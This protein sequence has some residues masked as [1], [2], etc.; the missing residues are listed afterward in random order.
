MVGNN[1][2]N[3]AC[4]IGVEVTRGINAGLYKDTGELVV[5]L[6]TEDYRPAEEL[7][8]CERILSTIIEILNCCRVHKNRIRGIGI[9]GD[10]FFTESRAACLR[11]NGRELSIVR[12]REILEESLKIPTCC[13][14]LANSL[15]IA[16]KQ[17]GSGKQ[18][19][20]FIYIWYGESISAGVFVD[21]RVVAAGGPPDGSLPGVTHTQP[22][23][24]GR[25][26]CL[27]SLAELAC[28]R[29]LIYKALSIIRQDPGSRMA[30]MMK[31][32][33]D[34]LDPN[35]IYT[36][37]LGGDRAARQI[38]VNKNR[39]LGLALI[40]LVKLFDPEVI[41]WGGCLNAVNYPVLIKS[42]EQSLAG[43]GSMLPQVRMVFPDSG[44]ERRLWAAAALAMY[45]TTRVAS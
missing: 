8:V 40:D 32:R 17:S 18:Y 37:A 7:S 10:I 31:S 2:H 11:L 38:I 15:A 44:K 28:P 33:P 29:A 36:A 4:Y 24:L 34:V 19:R 14:S 27:Y 16:E 23:S 26:N 39:H 6:A 21:D 43:L 13:D 25:E 22:G 41:F 45:N 30:T 12:A 9:C 35:F 5:D 1:N 20:N 42:L 3:N